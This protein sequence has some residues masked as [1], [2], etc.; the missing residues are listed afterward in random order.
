M[1]KDKQDWPEFIIT[2]ILFLV[3]G[4]FVLY[5]SGIG[6][7]TLIPNTQLITFSALIGLLICVVIYYGDWKFIFDELFLSVTLLVCA[8]IF[9]M[10]SFTFVN[11]ITAKPTL[12]VEDYKII[13]ARVTES[14]KRSRKRSM[15]TIQHRNREMS[16]CITPLQSETRMK[17]YSHIKIRKWQ[18]LFG[19]GAEVVEDTEFINLDKR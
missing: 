1:E 18:G 10:V 12:L 4:I 15:V 19:F 16:I 3:F 6:E 17:K 5:V 7:L 13:N 2:N 14:G 11:Y 8:T 9:V